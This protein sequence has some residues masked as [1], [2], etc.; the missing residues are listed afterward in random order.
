MLYILETT[1]NFSYLFVTCAVSRA[2][3]WGQK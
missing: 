3:E 1:M 2:C